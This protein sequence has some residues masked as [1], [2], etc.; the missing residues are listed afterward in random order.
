M[1]EKLDHG[2]KV[3]SVNGK[4]S[5]A[6]Y[7]PLDNTRQE[8]R[9]LTL[10]PSED[11]DVNIRCTLSHAVLNTPSG[12]PAYE[13]LSYVWGEP[14]FS[15]PIILNY[16]TFFITPSLK[17]IL[18][19]LK[20]RYDQQR[21]LWVD[22]ICINQS[23]VEE[24]GHQVALLHEIYLNCQRDIA[25]LDPMILIMHGKAHKLCSLPDFQEEEN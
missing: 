11:K 3:M 15:E 25:W 12:N 18:S 9:L 4:V 17:Y 14:D 10:L 24:R 21:V 20:Q 6:I 22:A 13:A 23:D 16:H 19:C 1:T 8:I 5:A 2:P 7:K